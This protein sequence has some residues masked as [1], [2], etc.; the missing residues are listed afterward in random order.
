MENIGKED[1]ITYFE[2]RNN[3]FQNSG[4]MEFGKADGSVLWTFFSLLS[5]PNYGSMPLTLARRETVLMN[6]LQDLN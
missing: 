3:R 5:T 6:L 1:L 2:K 4:G